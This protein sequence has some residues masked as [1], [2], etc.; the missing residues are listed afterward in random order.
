VKIKNLLVV[1]VV[2]MAGLLGLAQPALGNPW[3]VTG[4]DGDGSIDAQAT[5]S[6]TGDVVTVTLQNLETTPGGAS[7]FSAGQLLSGVVFDVTGGSSITGVTGTGPTAD[8]TS[9]NT[10]TTT[11]DANLIHSGSNPSGHWGATVSG[12]NVYLATVGKGAAGGKPTELIIGPTPSSGK[13]T[14]DGSLDA[15]H[16]P[17]V[18]ETA[19]FTLTIPDVT[20]A[21]IISGVFLEFGT[22][23]DV[24]RTAANHPPNVPDGGTTVCL[25]GLALT[26]LA[27]MRRKMG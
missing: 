12:G 10:F 2:G 9:A 14:L 22:G 3:V 5:F 20:A 27:L 24:T 19:T 7:G 4:S 6:I 23:P 17:S 11:P 1:G 25:L 26:G 18:I 8:L 15:N 16:E 13:Y 21:S